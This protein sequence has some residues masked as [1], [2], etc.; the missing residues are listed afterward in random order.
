MIQTHDR[1]P[2]RPPARGRPA[3]RRGGIIVEL[4]LTLPIFLILL[5]AVVQFGLY[6]VNMQQVALASRVGAE[7]AS[8]TPDLEGFAVVPPNV[9]QA[10]EHQ[11]QTAGIDE[12]Q[13]K[14]EHNVGG[15]AVTLVSQAQGCECCPDEE[16]DAPAYG[17]YVRLT[18]CVPLT[19]L[20][21]NCLKLFCY[22]I[23]GKTTSFT[24]VFRYELP[25]P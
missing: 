4:V 24:T 20:M 18:V 23:T 7:E 2:A 9:V 11:L 3:R 8:Q 15:T 5:V 10:I 1:P 17:R 22:D 25:T 12:C 13:V 19:E 21:P 6:H 14:L 16:L